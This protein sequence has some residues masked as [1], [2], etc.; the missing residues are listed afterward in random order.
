MTVIIKK[1]VDVQATLEANQ[2]KYQVKR[3]LSGD[4]QFKAAGSLLSVSTYNISA[5]YTSQDTG[6]EGWNFVKLPK[7]K[8]SG[9]VTDSTSSMPYA[10]WS[11]IFKVNGVQRL[12]ETG[13]A[14]GS[15]STYVKVSVTET[16]AP[17]T[18][19]QSL[20][21]PNAQTLSLYIYTIYA[22]GTLKAQMLTQL[23][24]NQKYTVMK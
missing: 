12:Q 2:L 17:R 22:V 5:F 1:N 7:I 14:A 19:T 15:P 20:V 13:T 10:H 16:P 21:S 24:V 6:L 3:D 8:V 23:N 18:L 4:V 9:P 11:V